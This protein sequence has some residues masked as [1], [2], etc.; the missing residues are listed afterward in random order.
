M[1]PNLTLF[2]VVLLAAFAGHAAEPRSI[3]LSV[4][5]QRVLHRIDPK[6]YGQFLEHIYHSCNGGLWGDIVWNRSFDA[7][8][9]GGRWCVD[10]QEIVQRGNGFNERMNFGSQKWSDYEFTLQAQKTGGREG[11]LV[12]VRVKSNRD[13]FRINFGAKVQTIE[14]LRADGAG[15]ERR[16]VGELARQVIETGRWY[17]VRVRCDGPRIQVWLDDQRLFDFTDD[18]NWNR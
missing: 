7:L 2:T 9:G 1:K 5:P 18:A 8:P 11:F 13:Q 6:V 10:G 16:V 3:V 15:L 17:N 14:R 4:D 12:F